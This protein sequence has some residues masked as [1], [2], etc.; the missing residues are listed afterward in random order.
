MYHRTTDIQLRHVHW[1]QNALP[2]PKD[3]LPLVISVLGSDLSLLDF[4]GVVPRLR[5]VF[6]HR[7]VVLC[8]NASWMS[9]RLIEKFAGYAEV[10]PLPFGID[11]SWFEIERKRSSPD[12]WLCVSRLTPQKI[13]PLFSWGR[14]VFTD[15][16]RQLHLIGPNQAGMD[17]P[18]WVHYHGSLSPEDIR[19]DWFP[20]AKGLISLSRHSEGR[21][22]VMLE[23]MAS[24]IPVLASK[25]PAHCDFVEHRVSGW[26]CGGL[27]EFIEGVEC[28]SEE[29][30]NSAIGAKARESVKISSGTWDS[31]AERLLE[32]YRRALS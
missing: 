18:E 27:D 11:Q 31:F 10:H 6:R 24:G 14:A 2:I 4:P 26:L 28:L 3:D 16:K 30:A 5:S 25:V 13:G 15:G 9:A 29:S 20:R 7:R 1:L 8:P 17:V 23:A 12:I 19:A 22:Q 32:V 21:P